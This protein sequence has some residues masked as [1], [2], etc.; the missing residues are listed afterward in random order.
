M[1]ARE[2]GDA[3]HFRSREACQGL[4][5]GGGQQ[6]GGTV[7]LPRP[8]LHPCAPNPFTRQTLI[9]YQFGQA[10]SVHLRACDANGRLVRTFEKGQRSPG[11]R[12]QTWNG[13]DDR[14]RSAPPGVYFVRLDV[15]GHGYTQRAVLVR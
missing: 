2:N 13:T 6:S 9:R 8:R 7:E 3:G 12:S 10:G 5:G 11:V 1:P 14:G 4:G 15:P